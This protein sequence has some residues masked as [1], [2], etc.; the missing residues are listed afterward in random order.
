M[1]KEEK[2]KHKILTEQ[3]QTRTGTLPKGNDIK[4]KKSLPQQ[5]KWKN[6]K[7]VNTKQMKRKMAGSDT[8]SV[9]NNSCWYT[10]CCAAPLG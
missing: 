4:N 5:T 1:T 3:H 7:Y 8:Q 9:L 6:Y 2:D 10:T